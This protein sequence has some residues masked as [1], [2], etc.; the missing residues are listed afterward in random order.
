MANFPTTPRGLW[1]EEF[2]PGQRL[3]TSGRTVTE[4]DVVNFAGLSGDYNPVHVDARYSAQSGFGQRVAHGILVISIVSGLLVQTGLL[5]G[6]LGAFREI[7]R[8]KFKAP[9]FIG[10]TVRAEMTILETRTL[11][12][13]DG[14]IV[15]IGLKVLNQDGDVVMTG[16][17]STL[18]LNRPISDG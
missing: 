7:K 1:F 18:V 2:E 14:G 17:W 4:A 8:W 3:I 16:N 5:D 11:K 10:D 12:G 15:E 6:T 13:V 9:I